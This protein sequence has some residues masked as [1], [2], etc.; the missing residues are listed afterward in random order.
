MKSFFFVFPREGLRIIEVC[1]VNRKFSNN[2][3]C[4]LTSFPES[5]S[6]GLPETVV[7]LEIVAWTP[8]T[9]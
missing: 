3:S 7:V 9:F 2:C 4:R 1:S 6:C 5:I 8:A